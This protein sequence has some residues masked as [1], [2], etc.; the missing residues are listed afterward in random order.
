MRVALVGVGY[1]GKK[2]YRV[3]SEL[4][5]QV[6]PASRGD[7]VSRI[8]ADCAVIA[9]PPET[10]AAIAIEA[11]QAGMDVLVEK[12]MALRAYDAWDM[13]SVA[14]ENRRVLSVDNTFMH[15]EAYEFLSTLQEPIMS[16]QS[17][18]IAP[19]LPHVKTPAGWDLVSHD[20]GILVGMGVISEF[21]PV[22]SSQTMD[23]AVA[24][25]GLTGCGTAHIT[26]SRDWHE[27]Q[28]SVAMRFPS[29]QYVWTDGRLHKDKELVVVEREETLKRVIKDFE[30]RIEQRDLEGIT[31]GSVGAEVCEWL[32]RLF[33]WS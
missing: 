20:L 29:G 11:M 25:I 26:A 5:H 13:Q 18:R 30:R 2:L 24:S 31:D 6:V 7:S 23:M 17:L 8:V 22:Q 33:P 15:T 10:H 27:K 3:L 12:P 19:P 32:E 4:G 28:R 21:A 16:Y 9:T 14:L 1:W